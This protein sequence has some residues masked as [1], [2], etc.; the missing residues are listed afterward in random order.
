MSEKEEVAPERCDD[1]NKKIV[2][3]EKLL[4]RE[5]VES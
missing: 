4:A 3:I 2:V 1:L 5:S